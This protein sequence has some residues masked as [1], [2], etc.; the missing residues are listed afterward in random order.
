[1][2]DKLECDFRIHSA[3]FESLKFS[4]DIHCNE[5]LDILV[6]NISDTKGLIELELL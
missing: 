3:K 6:Q 1:M 2:V 5:L 4:S